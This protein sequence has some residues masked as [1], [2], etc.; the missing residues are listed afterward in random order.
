MHRKSVRIRL[1]ENHRTSRA[2][3]NQFVEF[4]LVSILV[5]YRTEIV[6]E[7]YSAVFKF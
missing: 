3:T 1:K 7:V 4:K 2:F 5:L 6:E